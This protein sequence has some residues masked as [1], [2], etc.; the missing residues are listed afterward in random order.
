VCTFLVRKRPERHGMGVLYFSFDFT[1]AKVGGRDLRFVPLQLAE[2]WTAG[3]GGRNGGGK[4]AIACCF[5][6]TV[7]H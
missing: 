5:P 3:K 4:G 6:V 2:P 1:D 7:R